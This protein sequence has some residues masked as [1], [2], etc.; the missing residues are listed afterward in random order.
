[1]R[2]TLHGRFALV[3]ACVGALV[4]VAGCSSEPGPPPAAT[5]QNFAVCVGPTEAR[6]AGQQVALEFRQ[7]GQL[8]A[9]GSIP[10]GAA[11]MAQVP[12]GAAIDVYADGEW[13][14]GGGAAPGAL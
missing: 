9:T 6:P 12:V 2:R 4:V 1:M 8:V 5:V 10:V 11:F 13:A 3:G 7:G 14:G